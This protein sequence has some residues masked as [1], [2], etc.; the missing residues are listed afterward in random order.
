MLGISYATI[1]SRDGE[2]DGIEAETME[3]NYP[4]IIENERINRLIHHT[5]NVMDE[6][7]KVI[8]D[9]LLI[10]KQQNLIQ[11]LKDKSYFYAFVVGQLEGTK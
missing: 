8:H 2:S 1:R 3:N 7:C 10:D 6:N 11:R 5:F 9:V 4:N